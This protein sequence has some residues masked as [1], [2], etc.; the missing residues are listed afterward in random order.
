MRFVNI[1]L[2]AVILG[3]ALHVYSLEMQSRAA[4]KKLV[5]LKAAIAEERE[6][7][8]RLRAEWSHLNTPARLEKLAIRYLKHAPSQVPQVMREHEIGEWVRSLQPEEE[9]KAK[10]PIADM[11]TGNIV[12]VE[13]R[14]KVMK[15][16]PDLIADILKSLN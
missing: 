3:F 11:L 2:V 13:Q 5:A 7:I 6:H 4:G 1:V 16:E 10:D 12:A 14:P 8:R 15:Q 9:S